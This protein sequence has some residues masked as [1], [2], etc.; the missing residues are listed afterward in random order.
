MP[1]ELRWTKR[2]AQVM[3]QSITEAKDRR[4][5]TINVEHLLI[6]LIKEQEG[7]AADVLRQVLPL[8]SQA[9][10]AAIEKVCAPFSRPEQVLVEP[11]LSPGIHQVLFLAHREAQKAHHHYIGTEHMLLGLISS[12]N[13][14]MR[15]ILADLKISSQV[16]RLKLHERFPEISP[17]TGYGERLRYRFTEEFYHNFAYYIPQPIRKLFPGLD[18]SKMPPLG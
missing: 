13:H 7:A 16:V 3:A 8:E 15:E 2:A 6:A 18:S 5:K 9:V 1:T 10:V 14:V 17:R 4:S 11:E 12:S